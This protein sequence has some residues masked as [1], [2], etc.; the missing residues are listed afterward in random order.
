VNSL[1]SL[2][3]PRSIAVVGASQDTNKIRGRLLKLLVGGGYAGPVYPVNPS[4]DVIQGMKAYPSVEALPEP[5]DLALIAVAAAQVMEVLEQCA[6]RGVKSAAIFSAGPHAPVGERLQDEVEA[7]AARTGMRVLGPNAEGYLDAEGGLVATFSPTLE[8]VSPLPPGALPRRERVSIVSQSGAMAYALYSRA[9]AQ[10]IPVRHLVSTGNEADVELLEVVD[11]LIGQGTSRAILMFVEGL[12]HPGRLAAVAA[13]AADAGV[14]LIVAKI[15]RSGAGQRAAVSHTAHLTGADTAYDAAFRRHGVIRVDK[16]EQMLALAAAVSAGA[17]PR[18]PRVGIITTSGGAGGWAADICEQA[19]LEVPELVPAFKEQLAAI[20]PDYGSA[21]NPVDV[22]ARVVEDGGS[23][24]MNILDLVARADGIDI[25]LIIVSLVL[26]DRIRSIEERLATIMAASPRPIVFHSPGQ[27]A[28]EGLDI[29]AE[30]GG[31]HLGLEDFAQA[32]KRLCDHQAFLRRWRA[33]RLDTS[34]PPAPR[35]ALAGRAA[36]PL[37]QV[38]ARRL[39]AAYAVPMPSE[40]LAG[41]AGEAVRAARAMGGPVALKIVSPDVPHKTEAGGV[42][43]GVA[44]DEAVAQAHERVLANVRRHA[45]HA[46]I[47]GVQV[48]KMMPAGREMVVGVVDDPDFGPMV[49]LGFGGVYVEVLRDVAF[50]LAPVDLDGARAMIDGLKGVDILR[51][52]RG[53]AAS[54]VEALARLL[55]SVS[56]LAAAHAGRIAE[57]D[58]NPVMVFPQGQGVCAVDTLVVMADPASASRSEESV[59]LAEAK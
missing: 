12:K 19:G 44:G 53:Q 57:I 49:M 21:E 2:F 10:H 9:R 17:V 28:P 8:V 59:Q 32:M 34:R 29:L 22:T 6:R 33:S 35:L 18:G 47:E 4:S 1:T 20:V 7:F 46:R 27:P 54:D 25:G 51:G 56:E 11:Y 37:D 52:A 24:L 50:A 13:K 26:P 48:Q 23:T 41:S 58:L 14:A 38:E 55:V 3:A 43:L 45:P 5:V 30:V 39:L 31:V 36:G 42:V 40:T 15:G 16:P